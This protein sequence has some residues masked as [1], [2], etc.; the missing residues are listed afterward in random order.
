[1][2]IKDKIIKKSTQLFLKYGFK[3]VTVDEIAEAVGASKKTLYKHFENKEEIIVG[4][5]NA[6]HEEIKLKIGIIFSQNK[7]AI[8]EHFVIRNMFN[9]LLNSDGTSPLYQL[10]KHYPHIFEEVRCREENQCYQMFIENMKKGLKDN[11]YRKEI[12]IEINAQLYYMLIFRINESIAD[13]KEVSKLELEAMKF[14]IHSI[15][16]QKGL[17]EFYKYYQLYIIN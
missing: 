11:L 7:N 3:S 2:E 8:E 10:K 6:V 12:D 9:E 13:E 1:V 17:E 16:T 14:F 4:S 15:A 5:L